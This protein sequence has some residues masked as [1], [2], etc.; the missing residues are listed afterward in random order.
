MEC[1]LFKFYLFY[2]LNAFHL[3][4]GGGLENRELCGRQKNIPFKILTSTIGHSDKT[5]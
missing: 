4:E 2:S 5:I 3:F 1:N